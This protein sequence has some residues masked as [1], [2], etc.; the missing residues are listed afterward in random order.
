MAYRS[1]F[2]VFDGDKPVP[3][4]IRNYTKADFDQLI[5]IQAECFPPPF[6]SELWWNKEQLTNHVELFPDGALCIE[7]EGVLAGSLT[8]LNVDFDPSHPKHTWEEITDS[9]Y[10]R[11]HNPQGNTLYIVDI[12]VRPKFR[13]LGLG[14]LM[15]QAMYQVVINLGLD[16]LLGGGRMP[17]Y[18]KFAHEMSAVDYLQQLIDGKKKDPVITF[19]LRCGRTPLSVAEN[20][21]EDEESFNYAAL[22][23][24]KNPFKI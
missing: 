12:S 21:L 2:Y 6:P 11:N 5:D 20:Y 7:F 3:A 17:G 23:E 13:K 15:M 19:L 22:M 8:G 10:I 14:K 9:G 18:H 24:W 16:R 1:E 4:V